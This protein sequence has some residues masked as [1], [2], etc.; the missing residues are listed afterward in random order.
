MENVGTYENYNKGLWTHIGYKRTNLKSLKP[1]TI[2]P[3]MFI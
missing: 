2:L 3:T 1:K